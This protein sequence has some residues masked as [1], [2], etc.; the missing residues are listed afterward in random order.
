MAGD[1]CGRPPNLAGQIPGNCVLVRDVQTTM[2]R[3]DFLNASGLAG[4]LLLLQACGSGATNLDPGTTA[5]PKTGGSTPTTG[6][7]TPT[8]GAGTTMTTTGTT[9]SGGSVAKSGL[10]QSKV[11]RAKTAAGDETA[12]VTALNAFGA[13]LGQQLSP[14]GNVVFSPAS[15]LLAMAMVRAG[16]VGQTQ[17]EMNSALHIADPSTI[18]HSINALLT[19]LASRNGHRQSGN[20]DGDIELDIAN[21]IW[22]QNDEQWEQAF[23][24]VLASQYAAGVLLVDYRHDA[25]AAESAINAWVSEQTKKRIPELLTPGLLTPT[26]RMVLVNTIYLKAPWASAFMKSSTAPAPFIRANGSSVQVD[27]MHRQGF[28]AYVRGA[29]LEAVTLPYVGNE[30]EMALIVPDAGKLFSVF[31]DVSNTLATL[32]A[33]G[34]SMVN[35]AMPKFDFGTKTGLAP[36]LSALGM[37]TAFTDHA[38]FSG[39]TKT[40]PLVISAVIHQANITVDEEGTV[41]AAATAAVM[42]AGAAAA[43]PVDLTIDRPFIFAIRDAKNGAVLFLGTIN[44]PTDH[45]GAA[46]V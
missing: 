32:T 30:L 19:V 45:S 28:M 33:A 40:E 10:A 7:S 5:P 13:S 17:T 44:D 22:A 3:R 14:T 31:A 46:T 34:T 6:G 42:T 4:A 21:S 38:D 29:D 8:T 37:P 27:M 16:A 25:S 43:E 26:T 36:T 24:D 41:A 39:M 18:D 12:A 2:N 35:L 11:P 9:T 20:R 1:R 15:I 23:L